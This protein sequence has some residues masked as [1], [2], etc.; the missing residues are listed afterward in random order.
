M[1]AAK[2]EQ[3]A[4]GRITRDQRQDSRRPGPVMTQTDY[5]DRISN[6]TAPT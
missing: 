3:A 6:L 2:I 5:A 1:R 4:F